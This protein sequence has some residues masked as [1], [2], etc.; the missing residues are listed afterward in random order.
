[1]PETNYTHSYRSVYNLTAHMVFVTKYRKKVLSDEWL[2]FLQLCFISILK[3]KDCE[4]VEFNGECDHVHLIVSYKPNMNVSDL[5]ANLK[6]TSSKQM[7]QN[8][9]DDLVKPYWGKRVLWTGSYFVAS[10]GGVTVDILKKYIQDQDS[11]ES[12]E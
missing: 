12:V 10:C 5:V 2:K 6:S 1:M 7:W 9:A 4:L 3:A 11:P 8:Y